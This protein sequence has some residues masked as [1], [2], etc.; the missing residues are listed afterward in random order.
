MVPRALESSPRLLA[1]TTGLFYL[2]TILAGL[3]AQLF[4]SDRLVVYGDAAAT[5]A[6]LLAHKRLFELG[7]S[8]YLL[9]MACQI[10]M[11]A[12]FYILLKPV[13]SSLALLAAC[14]SL[15]GCVIKTL[16]RLFYIAPLLVL[17]G[18]H[19]MSAF[20]PEQLQALALLFLQVNDQ[21]AA[22]AL[23]FFGFSTSLNGYLM[24]RSTFLP[25]IIGALSA[26]AGAGWLTFLYPPLG[27]RLF[28]FVAP[29]ALLVAAV[30]IFWLL[31]KGVDVQ[32]WQ[33]RAGAKAR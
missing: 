27:Y 12:L 19:D 7:F 26:L 11:T 20:Q 3:C 5:A 6:N 25:R 4:I 1:R 21:G 29:F 15:T 31:K 9:E 28:P 10:A 22:L 17:G 33:E 13:S 8:I 18:T 16:S 2:L 24:F 14:W 32:R 23:A 30:L